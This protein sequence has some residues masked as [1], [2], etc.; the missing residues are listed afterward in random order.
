LPKKDIRR[1]TRIPHLGRVRISWEGAHGVSMFTLG[2]CL[3]VSEGGMRIEVS[4]PIPA[5][6]RVLLQ[7]D[8]I[9]VGGSAS[10]KHVARLGSKYILGLELSQSIR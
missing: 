3:D 1:H 6:S 4:E 9:K 8:Q 7:A 5:R 10:V 2:K